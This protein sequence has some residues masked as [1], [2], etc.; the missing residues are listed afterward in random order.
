VRLDLSLESLPANAAKARAS[1]ASASSKRVFMQGVLVP[2]FFIVRHEV[3]RQT[4]KPVNVVFDFTDSFVALHRLRFSRCYSPRTSA[5]RLDR[6]GNCSIKPAT[7]LLDMTNALSLSYVPLAQ[8][9]GFDKGTVQNAIADISQQTG[10]MLARGMTLEL[11]F[12]FGVVQVARRLSGVLH[13]FVC[14]VCGYQTDSPIGSRAHCVRPQQ[15]RCLGHSITATANRIVLA[16]LGVCTFG[17]SV[18]GFLSQ[19]NHLK[20]VFLPPPASAEVRCRLLPHCI[21]SEDSL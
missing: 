20:F 4:G 3:D 14:V 21:G 19:A 5:L 1:Y 13:C 12:S 10:T 11:S 6:G 9:C 2:N 7:A 17:E 15:C 18:E 16:A 8:D